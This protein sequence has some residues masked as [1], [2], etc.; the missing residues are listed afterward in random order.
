MNSPQF[1]QYQWL[2]IVIGI[3]GFILGYIFIP[4][5]TYLVWLL[6]ISLST[7]VLYGI[8]KS[9]AKF[10][11]GKNRVPKI[12]LHILAVLGGFAGAWLGMVFFRHKIRQIEFW[13]VLIVST[14][15]HAV[16]ISQLF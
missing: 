3:I 12:L 8:D 2:A 1:R 14:L 5:N 9:N 10:G 15:L 6:A 13:I 16:V 7:L 11:K 4:V